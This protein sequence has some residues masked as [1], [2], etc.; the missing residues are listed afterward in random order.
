MRMSLRSALACIIRK[1]QA[2]RASNGEALYGL[3]FT[4]DVL[5]FNNDMIPDRRLR[6]LNPVKLS[7]NLPLNIISFCFKDYK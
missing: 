5:R 3:A 4:Q 6:L 1:I 7:R 2:Q